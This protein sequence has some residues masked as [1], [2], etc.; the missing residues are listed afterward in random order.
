MGSAINTVLASLGLL[1][2]EL[3]G[4]NGVGGFAER[5][6]AALVKLA[7]RVGGIGFA[8]RADRGIAAVALAAGAVEV[9]PG[10]EGGARH[11]RIG[12]P[13]TGHHLIH[14]RGRYLA[15]IRS[16]AAG[17]LH[18]PAVFRL[19]HFVEPVLRVFGLYFGGGLIADH[20]AGDV[21]AI[22]VEALPAKFFPF[23]RARAEEAEGQEGGADPFYHK[24][25]WI[26]GPR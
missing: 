17:Y 15:P 24:C 9:L 7:A 22:G 3:A 20:Q 8:A 16:A 23:F 25:R 10:T 6:H 11:F 1:L 14:H 13:G 26:G 21:A 19:V 18:L 5:D 2:P 4:V 12:I